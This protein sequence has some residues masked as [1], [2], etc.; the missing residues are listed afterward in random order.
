MVM[1]GAQTKQQLALHK[2]TFQIPGWSLP[3]SSPDIGEELPKV[4]VPRDIT[5]EQQQGV[6]C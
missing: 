6:L 1:H 4:S 5:N 2:G 3:L